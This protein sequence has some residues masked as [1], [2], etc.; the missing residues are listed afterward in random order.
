MK[1]FNRKIA[2]LRIDENGKYLHFV[3]AS[4]IGDQ[5]AVV[6]GLPARHVI[7]KV[8]EVEI[9]AEHQQPGPNVLVAQTGQLVYQ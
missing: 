3:N 8:G 1:R 7:G 2:R 5:V 4:A 9:A 6:K